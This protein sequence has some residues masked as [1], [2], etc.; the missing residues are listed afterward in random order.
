MAKHRPLINLKHLS[1]KTVAAHFL[2]L[3][4]IKGCCSARRNRI[5][6]LSDPHCKANCWKCC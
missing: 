5:A 2:F 1:Q 3:P 6:P 4:G